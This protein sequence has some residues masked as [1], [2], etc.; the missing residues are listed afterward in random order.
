MTKA[1]PRNLHM[2]LVLPVGSFPG[3]AE[4]A[5]LWHCALI[6]QYVGRFDV[7]VYERGGSHRVQVLEA[8]G[9]MKDHNDIGIFIDKNN[10]CFSK[11]MKIL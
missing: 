4:V 1:I 5:D 2:R 7:A 11:F 10:C 8:S 3:Q 9:R 6:Q